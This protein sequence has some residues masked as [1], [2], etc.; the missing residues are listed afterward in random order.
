MI[1][2]YIERLR[3]L[4]L[5]ERREA[6]QFLTIIIVGIIV[7]IYIVYLIIKTFMV[8]TIVAPTEPGLTPPY[9]EGQ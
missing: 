2:E 7:A 6:G 8:P 3:Q 4:P 9:Q 1:I 5:K